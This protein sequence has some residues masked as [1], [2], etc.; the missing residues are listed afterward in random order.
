[1]EKHSFKQTNAFAMQYGIMLGLWGFLT[2]VL[3]VLSN[4]HPWLG[5]ISNLFFLGSPVAGCLLTLRFRREVSESPLDAFSFGHGFTFSFLLGM[6]ACIWIALGVFIYFQW[7][8][9]GYICDLCEQ[10]LATGEARMQMAR[11]GIN[12]AQIRES[13]DRMR[14]LTPGA[15]AGAIVYLSL[16]ANIPISLVIALIA[17]R[18]E[19]IA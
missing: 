10:T 16:I 15:Y 17:R 3:S 1:M 4:T 9:H 11:N 12:E 13:I 14:S 8:D 19:R 5:W 18:S 7:F 6:Y 2:L